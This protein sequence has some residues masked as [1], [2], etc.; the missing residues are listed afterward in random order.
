MTVYSGFPYQPGDKV[1]CK[2]WNTKERET[3]N[4][5]GKVVRI[6]RT[7]LIADKE[8][9]SVIDIGNNRLVA[10][11]HDCLGIGTGIYPAEK[12]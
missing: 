4:Y 7:S 12:E 9:N 2:A 1:L 6:R 10:V 5:V 3:H 8:F 11:Y